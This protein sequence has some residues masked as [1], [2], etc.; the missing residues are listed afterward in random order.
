[1]YT[2]LKWAGTKQINENQILTWTDAALRI[3]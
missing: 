1:M 3:L 2:V